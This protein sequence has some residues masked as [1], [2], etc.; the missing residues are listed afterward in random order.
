MGMDSPH[1]FGHDDLLLHRSFVR[2]L[3]R[4]LVRDAGHAEDL[5]QDAWAR[6]LARPPGWAAAARAWFRVVL[7]NAAG[8]RA[9][10]DRDRAA[11]ERSAARAEALPSALE[12]AERLELDR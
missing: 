4:E 5:A 10:E 7:R 2:H 12:G 3:A 1:A 8:R 6:A 11:R 9:R